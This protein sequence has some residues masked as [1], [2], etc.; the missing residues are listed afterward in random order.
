MEDRSR[1]RARLVLIVGMLFA[2]GAGVATFFYAQTQ[3]SEAPAPI[4]TSQVVVAARDIPGKTQITPAD[5]K[6]VKMNT[7]A[8]PTTAIQDSAQVVGRITLVSISAGEPILP[9]RLAGP[10]GAAFV[11]IPAEAIGANGAPNPGSPNY[12][13]MSITVAD[14][15][16]AGGAILP[17]DIVDVLYTITFTP[18]KYLVNPQ[19]QRNSADVSA[20][21]VLERVPILARTLSVYVIRTDAA[22]AERIGFLTASGGQLQLLLRGPKD[23]RATGTTGAT[24]RTI[25]PE[26]KIQIPEK[27]SP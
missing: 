1:R 26:F 16:A 2:L 25:Q 21:I 3:K 11:V 7:D 19:P 8:V 18:D 5:I 6:L 27:I 10:N 24:F 13:A 20:R 15:Q 4:P 23:D 12:R 9:S 17:G 14:A 22:T